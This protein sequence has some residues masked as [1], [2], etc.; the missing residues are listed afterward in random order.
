MI[1]IPGYYLLKTKWGLGENDEMAAFAEDLNSV[2][3]LQL[4]GYL[5]AFW[6]SMGTA[7]PH[8]E[9]H[10]IKHIIK[11]SKNLKKKNQKQV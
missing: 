4:Q 9:R 10:I 7:C 5:I 6:V 3:K 2:C 11:N 1:F 8:M